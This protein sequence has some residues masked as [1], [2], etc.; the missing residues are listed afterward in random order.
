MALT[1]DEQRALAIECGAEECG[2]NFF[3]FNANELAAYTVA[4]EAKERDTVI[5]LI[6]DRYLTH[7][8]IYRAIDETRHQIT[9]TF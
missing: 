6:L 4:V 8:D 1:L 3:E 7:G 2:V 5:A 9:H